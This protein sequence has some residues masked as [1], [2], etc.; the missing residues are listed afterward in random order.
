M[1]FMGIL[2]VAAIVIWIIASAI[3]K[4]QRMALEAVV[5]GSRSNDP[6]ANYRSLRAGG[7]G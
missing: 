4:R 6:A 3:R 5:K 7:S 2:Y 1:I